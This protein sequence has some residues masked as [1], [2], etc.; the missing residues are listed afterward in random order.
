MKQLVIGLL[1]LVILSYAGCKI[2]YPSRTVNFRMTYEVE[3]P[4]GLKA[5]SGVLAATKTIFPEINGRTGWAA[6]NGEAVVVDLGKRGTFYALLSS[7]S[8]PGGDGHVGMLILVF[9]IADKTDRHE[10]QSVHNFAALSGRREMTYDQPWIIT[11]GGQ[12]IAPPGRTMAWDLPILVRFGDEADPRT[13]EAIDPGN[14]AASFGEGVRLKR[15][16]IEITDQPVTT[17]IQKRLTWLGIYPELSLD[18]DNPKL[19]EPIATA[20]LKRLLRH[21]QFRSYTQ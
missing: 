9:D 5:G 3:T 4:E 20:P 18:P 13:V 15:V 1:V 11:S 16:I 6:T 8:H 17:G 10:A 12:K 21:G 19:V 14:L 7:P 2:V